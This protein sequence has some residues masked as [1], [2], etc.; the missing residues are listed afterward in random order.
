MS[1]TFKPTIIVESIN[2]GTDEVAEVDPAIIR[3]MKERLRPS[4]P[5]SYANGDHLKAA[6]ENERKM[7]E[8][9]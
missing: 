7:R 8:G 4:K 1:N 3:E 6:E 5:F 9:K 2:V